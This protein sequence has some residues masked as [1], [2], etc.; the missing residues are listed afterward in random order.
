MDGPYD[1]DSGNSRNG[2]DL[3][4]GRSKKKKYIYISITVFGSA[5]DPNYGKASLVARNIPAAWESSQLIVRTAVIRSV[6]LQLKIAECMN[7]ANCCVDISTGLSDPCSFTR[8][9]ASSHIG[10]QNDVR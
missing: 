10:R 9:L 8:L 6:S 4:T 2:P 5:G 7:T 3:S 1:L